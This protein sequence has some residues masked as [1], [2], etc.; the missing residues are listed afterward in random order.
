[1]FTCRGRYEFCIKCENVALGKDIVDVE[2]VDYR[3]ALELIKNKTASLN[4]KQYL[5]VQLQGKSK[6]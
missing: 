3:K 2:S 1:M 5:Q 4:Q 6:R